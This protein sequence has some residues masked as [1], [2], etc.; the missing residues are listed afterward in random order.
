MSDLKDTSRKVKKFNNAFSSK[1]YF[2]TIM[3]I[4]TIII[5][6]TVAILI[7]NNNNLTAAI[8]KE[9]AIN[10]SYEKNKYDC[11]QIPEKY[12]EITKNAELK[13]YTKHPAINVT[14]DKFVWVVDIK[15]YNTYYNPSLE[16]YGINDIVDAQTG[17]ILF[18]DT[19][20]GIIAYPIE[21]E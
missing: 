14:S 4:I 11:S 5:T 9:E 19:S 12:V 15:Y 13:Y 18:H 21:Q 10:I 8:T 17:E 3:V 20:G 16:W 2:I 1:A 6:V 7:S